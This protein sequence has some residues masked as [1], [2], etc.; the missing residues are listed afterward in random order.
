MDFHDISNLEKVESCSVSPHKPGS[1]CVIPPSTI[2]FMDKSD[3]LHTRRINRLDCSVSSPRLIEDILV[4]K[5]DSRPIYCLSDLLFVEHKGRSV[6][7]VTSSIKIMAFDVKLGILVW[8]VDDQCP[9]IEHS[10]GA[11]AAV[12]DDK[13][14][15]FIYDCFNS[16]MHIILI[17]D[18]SRVGGLKRCPVFPIQMTWCK[19]STSHSTWLTCKNISICKIDL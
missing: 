2:L 16:C 11:S 12:A 5:P 14:H 15:L 1:L 9:G 6:L 19:H 18:G 17:D 13:G 10:I 3:K 7:V 4:A 8:E